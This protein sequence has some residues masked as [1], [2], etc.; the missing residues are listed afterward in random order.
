MGPSQ[1]IG[2]TFVERRTRSPATPYAKSSLLYVHRLMLF[3]MDRS[4]AYPVPSSDARLLEHQARRQRTLLPA[5]RSHTT[6]MAA[7]TISEYAFILT[8]ANLD[9]KLDIGTEY[10]HG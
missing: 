1:Q 2:S 3:M 8:T 10:L 4:Q 7:Y 9:L 6:L 5:R